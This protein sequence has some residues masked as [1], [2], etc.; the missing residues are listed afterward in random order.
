MTKNIIQSKPNYFGIITADIRYSE[1]LNSTEKLIC[2]EIYSLCNKKGYCWATNK[3]F[4][5]LYKISK[6]RVSQIISKLLKLGFIMIEIES[7]KGNFRKIWIPFARGVLNYSLIPIKL[8]F[9][10]SL[11]NIKNSLSSKEE[12][13][14]ETKMVSLPPPLNIPKPIQ[15]I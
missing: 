11:N 1:E 13:L 7:S 2:C 15:E 14:N 4:S 3:Y 5:N 9:N 6:T 8:N 12:R 10:T